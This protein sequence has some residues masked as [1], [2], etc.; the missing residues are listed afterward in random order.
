MTRPHRIKINRNNSYLNMG[1]TLDLSG[2]WEIHTGTEQRP[3]VPLPHP[4]I[5]SG[6]LSPLS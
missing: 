3:R 1:A 2:M 4:T 6:I 5:E